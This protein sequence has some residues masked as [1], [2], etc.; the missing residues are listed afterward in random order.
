MLYKEFVSIL[1]N[2]TIHKVVHKNNSRTHWPQQN[3]KGLF[4][5][6]PC[7]FQSFYFRKVAETKIGFAT[8]IAIFD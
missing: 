1:N 4:K 3:K 6:K 5:K 8:K 7:L 2:F